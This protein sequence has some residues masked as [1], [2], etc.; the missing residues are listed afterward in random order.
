M[1]TVRRYL[2][3]LTSLY[4]V[5]QL[6]PWHANLAKR[7]VKAPKVYIRDTGLLHALHGLGT[8]REIL[9]NPKAGASW[10]GYAL[11]QLVEATGPD[12]AYF[13]AT[14]TG[15]ELDL[16]LFKSGRRYGVEMKLQDAPR[17]TPSMRIA[18]VD[19]GLE[20]LTVIYP[21]EKIYPLADR[22][23]AM[24]LAAALE[25]PS[26]VVGSARL[27]EVRFRGERRPMQSPAPGGSGGQRQ[28][29]STP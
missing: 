28:Q 21:G 4:L 3:L 25:K 14:H 11:E 24:P 13:W 26:L 18:L 23:E 16:L 1:P 6:P 9:R 17:L 2:D 10:E 22:V 29:C 7:Q 12:A 8:E 19:L 20:R 27:D 15:A 5:R